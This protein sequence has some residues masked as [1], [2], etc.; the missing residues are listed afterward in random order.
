[1]KIKISKS[2]WQA[3]GKKAGWV[4]AAQQESSEGKRIRETYDIVSEESAQMGDFEDSGWI[5]EDGVPID[6]VN[7]AIEHLKFNGAFYPSASGFYPGCWY[8]TE[9][10]QDMKTGN[11]ET[12]HYH[13]VN[14]TRDEQEEIY[15]AIASQ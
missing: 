3:L 10:S 2:Q 12:R 6:D 11:Y 4:K 9:P 7:E 14:F 15:N 13:L 8:S 1:M 5:N